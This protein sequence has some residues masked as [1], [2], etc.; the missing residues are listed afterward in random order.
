METSAADLRELVEE[1]DARN[2]SCSPPSPTNDDKSDKDPDLNTAQDTQS[3]VTDELLLKS[4]SLRLRLDRLSAFRIHTDAITFTSSEPHRCGGKAQ[5][6][7]ATLKMGDE[8]DEQQVAVKK[9]RY[10]DD[11]N[12]RKFGNEFVHEVVIMAR[13]SHDNTVRLIGF[14]E[15]LEEGKAWIVLSWEPNG[16]LSEFL[17]TGEWEIPERIS[18]IQDTF[19]GIEYLHTHQPRICHGDLKS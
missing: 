9:L 13:L 16:N 5:V 17:A 12:G 14:V 2:R 4:S 18:L 8:G 7:K 10:S 19:A 6:I 1:P 3:E 15:D 11:I